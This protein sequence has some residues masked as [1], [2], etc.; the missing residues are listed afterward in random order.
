MVYSDVLVSG[1]QRNESVTHIHISTLV[2]YLF[3]LEYGCFTM[4]C[5][6]LLYSKAN[7]LYVYIY[8]LSLGFLSHLGPHRE[9]SR[10]PVLFSRFSLVTYFIHSISIVYTCHFQS[11]NLSY[12]PF[13]LGIHRFVP[14]ICLSFCFANKITCT[15]F[16]DST[17]MCEYM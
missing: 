2:F 1:V 8:P 4:L 17:Y 10:F 16:L 6:F 5:Y 7:L 9:L 13:P 3:S 14:Y 12:P 11:T 15:I